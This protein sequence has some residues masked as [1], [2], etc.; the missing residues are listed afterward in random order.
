MREQEVLENSLAESRAEATQAR[1][2]HGTKTTLGFVRMAI[3]NKWLPNAFHKLKAHGRLTKLAQIATRDMEE[4]NAT[5]A[6]DTPEARE[7]VLEAGALAATTNLEGQLASSEDAATRE[8]EKFAAQTDAL[9]QE[10]DAARQHGARR[11]QMH[12][13]EK[14][15]ALLARQ[16]TRG[17]HL[18]LHR[19]RL[20][21]EKDRVGA[22]GGAAREARQGPRGGGRAGRGG[23]HAGWEE[24]VRKG[25]EEA[26][27]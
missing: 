22:G 25:L 1:R 20:W 27:L 26:C 3:T 2:I 13:A 9:K 14:A 23:E 8:Q 17:L 16:D 24:G 15:F 6:E 4:A 5:A 12:A 11:T 19:W 21:T 18:A 7:Q 10:L